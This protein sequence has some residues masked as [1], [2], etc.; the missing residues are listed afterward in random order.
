[1][2]DIKLR[3]GAIITRPR[4]P[5]LMLNRL[6]A[7]LTTIPSITDWW[8]T[9]GLLLILMFISLLVG[10]KKQFLQ[11]EIFADSWVKIAP[12][13]A[14]TLLLTAI[15]EEGFF[16]VML[17][18]HLSEN[19]TGVEELAWAILSLTVFLVYHPLNALTFY[20]A[21]RPTFMNPIFLLLAGF[22][23][24]AC[25]IIYLHSGSIWPPVVIHWLTLVVWIFF[26]GGYR[27][28]HQPPIN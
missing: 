17:L 26:L 16:R 11:R 22:L 1:M 28:L 8:W 24:I 21:G 6:S 13:I 7:S 2:V 5:L 25:T 3:S 27:K 4:K 14:I 10:S 20:P 19:P 15:A 18:P 23:G 12:I 9:L